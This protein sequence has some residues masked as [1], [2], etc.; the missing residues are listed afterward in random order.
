MRLLHTTTLELHS[1]YDPGTIPRYSILSH[2]WGNAEVL[3][4]DVSA[5]KASVSQ[6]SL[7]VRASK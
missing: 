2:R 6:A 1:F 5:L 3:Y 7:G 4:E